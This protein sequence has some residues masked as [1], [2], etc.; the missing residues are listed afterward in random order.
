MKDSELYY[1]SFEVSFKNS[2]GINEERWI[3]YLINEFK[4]NP[5]FKNISEDDLCAVILEKTRDGVK[6][7]GWEENDVD[8]V[9]WILGLYCKAVAASFEKYKLTYP[10]LFMKIFDLYAF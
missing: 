10:Q 2:K 4:Y 3:N 1:Y 6:A 5:F 8:G 9:A 7:A